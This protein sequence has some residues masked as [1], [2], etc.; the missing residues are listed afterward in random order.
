[1]CA[2]VLG[3]PRA[4]HPTLTHFAQNP[5]KPGGPLPV[6]ASGG[7]KKQKSSPPLG[8]LAPDTGRQ[9][10]REDNPCFAVRIDEQSHRLFSWFLVHVRWRTRRTLLESAV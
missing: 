9:S 4:P 8:F 10:R 6:S 3:A 5:L 1:M 2:D 7:P